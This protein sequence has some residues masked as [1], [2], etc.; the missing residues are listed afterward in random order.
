ML[1]KSPGP[2][3]DTERLTALEELDVILCV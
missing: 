1:G 3:G 2:G